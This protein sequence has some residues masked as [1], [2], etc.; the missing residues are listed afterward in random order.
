[1]SLIPNFIKSALNVTASFLGV[2]TATTVF[3]LRDD[4]RLMITN[5]VKY[6]YARITLFFYDTLNIN[7]ELAP[8]VSAAIIQFINETRQKNYTVNDGN[9]EVIYSVADGSYI[10]MFEGNKIEIKITAESILIYSAFVRIEKLK[11][12]INVIYKKYCSP[13]KA[14]VYYMQDENTWKAPILRSPRMVTHTMPIQKAIHYVNEFITAH[15]DYNSKGIKYNLGLALIGPTRSG[16]STTIEHLAHFYEM[17]VYVVNIA[18]DGLDNPGLTKL[19]ALVPPNC[20]IVLE[21]IEKQLSALQLRKES[22]VTPDGILSAIDGLPR[23]NDGV[24]FIVTGNDLNVL[25]EFSPEFKA[26]LLRKGR[27]DHVISYN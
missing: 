16:K 1:M 19:F 5:S 24:I 11:E 23:L 8:R 18:A 10:A 7:R 15:G 9:T 4:I 13:K 27:I 14:L 12:F 20:I 26:S 25:D 2:T 17:P 21:E 6:M 22:R 3:L